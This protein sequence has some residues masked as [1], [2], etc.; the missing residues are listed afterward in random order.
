MVCILATSG[1]ASAAYV[2]HYGEIA[3]DMGS[4]F[5]NVLTLLGLQ[6]ATGQVTSESGSI[7]W[8]GT[9]DVD[10]GDATN[11][12]MT[13]PVAAL[14]AKGFDADNLLVVL[15]LNQTGVTAALDVHEFTLRFYTHPNGS[16]FFDALY[17]LSDARNT[18]ST[19]Q[20]TPEGQGT[21]SAG[22]VFRINFEENEFN[23][24]E[25][26]LFF[27][28]PGNR[29]GMIMNTPIDNSANDGPESFYIADAD[30]VT[31]TPEPATLSLLALGGLA[32]LRRRRS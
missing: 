26:T 22:Y 1:P 27:G 3:E 2:T 19:L 13:Q 6:T 12:S 18:A 31:V 30:V 23:E 20:L 15:N 24:N 10:G 5:G 8:D 11:S 4:G 9:Q 17:F 21:G 25:A 32:F 7:T 14:T 28:N 16:Q 29:I